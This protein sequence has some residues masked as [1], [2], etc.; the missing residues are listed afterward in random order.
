[1]SAFLDS[2][3]APFTCELRQRGDQQEVV[4]H[5][6]HPAHHRM[7]TLAIGPDLRERRDHQM[8][9]L[10]RLAGVRHLAR[11]YTDELQAPPPAIPAATGLFVTFEGP[12]GGGKSTQIRRLAAALERAGHPV[13]L[14]REPGGSPV[15]DALRSLLLDQDDMGPVTEFLIFTASRAELVRTVIRPALEAGQVVLCDRFTDSTYAY[16]GFGRGL[17]LPDLKAV[18]QVATGGLTPDLTV[19]L[20][21]PPEVGLARAQQVGAPDR[22]E[23]AGLGLHQRVRGGFLTLAQADPRR[24]LTLDAQ[25]GEDDLHTEILRTVLEKLS[26][27]PVPE[28]ISDDVPE[29]APE[30]RHLHPAGH[31]SA[32]KAR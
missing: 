7:D 15:G 3:Q 19:L 32:R 9:M 21:L 20:D 6:L 8:V 29:D 26:P 16:Q 10:A 24:F 27:Q 4:V 14:T 18:T 1:L 12:E 28:G 22:I 13:R 11:A 25:R 17:D 5:A 23:R 2:H 30:H 31:R